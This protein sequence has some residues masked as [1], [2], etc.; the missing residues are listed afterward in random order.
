M[1]ENKAIIP[2]AIPAGE[3]TALKAIAWPE[4]TARINAA[5]DLRSVLRRDSS[6]MV[7]SFTDA[8]AGYFASI[9]DSGE[10]GKRPVNPDALEHGKSML[11][12]K[13]NA[14]SEAVESDRDTQ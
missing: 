5:R 4:L 3:G 12:T 9:D 2:A 7:A 6:C 14:E 13:A 11:C 8:A 1:I 10:Q